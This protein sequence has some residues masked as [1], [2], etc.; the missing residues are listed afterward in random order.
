MSAARLSGRVALVTGGGG[1]IGRATALAMAREGARVVVAD[2]DPESARAAVAAIDAA[3]G[4]AVAEIGDVGEPAG[5][6]AT[7]DA[8]LARYGALD[9]VFNNAGVSPPPAPIDELSVDTFDEVVR[10]NLRGVFLV[11]RAAIRAMR[12]GGRSGAIVNMASSMAGWDALAGEAPYISTKHGVVGL[13]RAAALDAA[14][15]GIRVNAICPGV[16][17]TSL[18]VPDLRDGDSAGLRR[19]AQ[20]IPLRRVGRPEDVA[21][22]V[23]FLCCEESRHVTG[24]S[25]LLDG[26]QTLQSWSNA[27]DSSAYPDLIHRDPRG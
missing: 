27:P 15:F 7:A 10:V 1:T 24:A 8:A 13:T 6:D 16:V 9:V 2:R 21:A 12:D 18:G 17:Q 25:W 22:V 23:V 3:G 19:F 4:E 20:R 5:A 14:R 26:G 11:M